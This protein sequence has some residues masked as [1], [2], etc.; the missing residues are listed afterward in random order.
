M[1][2]LPPPER[3]QYGAVLELMVGAA[4]AVTESVDSVLQNG[5]KLSILFLVSEDGDENPMRTFVVGR[6]EKADIV[7]TGAG[8]SVSDVHLE[9]TQDAKGYYYLVDCNSTNGTFCKRGSRWEP[10][11]EATYVGLDELLLLGKYQTSIRKLLDMLAGK[12]VNHEE[13]TPHLGVQRDPDTG[14]IIPQRH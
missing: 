5:L 2:L 13:I 6:A 10:I 1:V 4:A 14:E 9:I 3:S 11:R 8:N 12:N 7:I